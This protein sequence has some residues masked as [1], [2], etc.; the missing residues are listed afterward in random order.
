MR[1]FI[2]FFRQFLW[3]D[4]KGKKC[5]L[6]APQYV[7]YITSS[8]QKEISDETVFPT[9]FGRYP[10][11]N[12]YT[13]LPLASPSTHHKLT[14]NIKLGKTI[15]TDQFPGMFRYPMILKDTHFIFKNFY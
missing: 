6:T 7:D 10:E 4:D 9:K 3:Y 2:V 8:I 15:G 12:N 1:K 13:N 5:K 14:K 11:T